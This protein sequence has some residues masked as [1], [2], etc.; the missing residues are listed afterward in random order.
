MNVTNWLK[1]VGKEILK[2]SMC[3]KITFKNCKI[4]IAN[5]V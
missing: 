4:K 2:K 5:I 1:I 3:Q